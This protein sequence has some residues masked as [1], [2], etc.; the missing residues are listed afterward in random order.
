MT[1]LSKLDLENKRLRMQVANMERELM[2]IK[3]ELHGQLNLREKELK[4][5]LSEKKKYEQLQH[6]YQSLRGSILG[7]CTIKYWRIRKKLR[8]KLSNK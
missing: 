2:I 1:E 5:F 8:T 7:K 6:K 4:E 3:Q